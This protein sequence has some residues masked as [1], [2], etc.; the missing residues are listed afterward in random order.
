MLAG[1]PWLV[2]HCVYLANAAGTLVDVEPELAAELPPHA[3]TNVARPAIAANPAR[4]RGR[5]RG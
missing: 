1:T 2:R 4:E 5:R 3:A